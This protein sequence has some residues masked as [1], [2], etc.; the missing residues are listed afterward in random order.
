VPD[1][2]VLRQHLHDEGSIAK[3]EM[4]KLIKDVT[5]VFSK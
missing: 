1:I 2:K 5:A 4:V 3:R